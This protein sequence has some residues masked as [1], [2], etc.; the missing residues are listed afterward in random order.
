MNRTRICSPFRWTLLPLFIA[1]AFLPAVASAH[2]STR[3]RIDLMSVSHL[4]G[5]TGGCTSCATAVPAC[6]DLQKCCKT[7][8]TY[9]H[10]GR[11]RV[12]CDPC[13]EPIRQVLTF[14]HPATGCYVEV[15]ICVP[16]C[17]TDCPEVCERC[18]LFGCGAKTYRWCCGYS[19]TIRFAANGDVR[20]IYRG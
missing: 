3:G 18:T 4:S 7:A 16:G 20:V 13:L 9:H 11:R 10:L 6:C 15:P 8:I 1:V 2:E 17:C 19:A 14:C 12:C 5:V